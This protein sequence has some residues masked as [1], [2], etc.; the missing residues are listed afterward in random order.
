VWLKNFKKNTTWKTEKKMCE[1]GCGLRQVSSL[2]IGGVKPSA[3]T[4]SKLAPGREP[5]Q[6]SSESM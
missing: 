3:S 6:T 2:V 4:C 1:T 5:N